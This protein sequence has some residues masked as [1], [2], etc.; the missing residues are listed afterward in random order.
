VCVKEHEYIHSTK[1]SNSNTEGVGARM[2]WLNMRDDVRSRAGC[3]GVAVPSLG[4]LERPSE[5]QK[6]VCVGGGGVYTWVTHTPP[7]QTLMP[8]WSAPQAISSPGSQP[9][10]HLSSTAPHYPKL[11]THA[12]TTPHS[13]T[14]IHTVPHSPSGHQLTW[15]PA[16]D[17]CCRLGVP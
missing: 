13:P 12:P 6:C 15:K 7:I 4:T 11:R 3:L 16:S 10:P 5:Q 14:D 1:G 8:M 17:V 2:L 9:A